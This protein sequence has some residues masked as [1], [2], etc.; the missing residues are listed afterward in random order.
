MQRP[1]IL[2]IL[3]LFLFLSTATA[4]EEIK[5]INPSFEGMPTLSRGPVGWVDC[6]FPGESAADVHPVSS[7]D[8]GVTQ[9][10]MDGKTYLGMVV[11]DNDT[12]EAVSQYL[13]SPFQ[14]DSVYSFSIYLARSTMYLSRSRKTNTPANYTT[15]AILRVWGGN[16][17]CDKAELLAETPEIIDALWMKYGIVFS[18]SKAYTYITLETYYTVPVLSPYNGNLLLDNC[19]PIELLS[20]RTIDPTERIQI[21]ASQIRALSLMER[22]KKDKLKEDT[23]IERLQKAI[24]ECRENLKDKDMLFIKESI[25]FEETLLE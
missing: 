7:S 2:S 22:D 9:E 8:F 1:I 4:Q 17:A 5:L 15:P 24:V 6:G 23:E 16:G 14:A 21:E 10:A 11:R 19:S 18:P 13:S 12:W 20:G 3:A 25:D